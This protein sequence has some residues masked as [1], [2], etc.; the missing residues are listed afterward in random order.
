MSGPT[1][2]AGNVAAMNGITTET[3]TTAVTGDFFAIQVLE[4][5]TFTTFTENASDGD[6]MTGFSIPAGTILYN[7]KGI[8]AFTMSSGKVRAYKRR[9]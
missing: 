9:V 7:G 3:G 1:D 5:A 2:L 8:T 6:D 4:A